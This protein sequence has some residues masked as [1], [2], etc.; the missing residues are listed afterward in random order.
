MPFGVRRRSPLPL[1][2]ALSLALATAAPALEGGG[3]LLTEITLVASRDG[4]RELLLRSERAT[5]DPSTRRAELFDVSAE[6]VDADESRRLRIECERAEVEIETQNFRAQ[7][8]VRG[9]TGEGQR[10][11]TESVRYD[12]EADLLSSDTPVELVD[13]RG[14]LRGDG[15]RYHVAER[16]FELLGNVRVEQGP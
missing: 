14:S 10:F 12:R 4:E 2:A 9:D 8:N 5:L 11:S 13:A 3:L 6:V 15:F 7:G 1:C 16:R